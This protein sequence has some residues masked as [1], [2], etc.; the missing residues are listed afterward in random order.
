MWAIFNQ[1]GV[2]ALAPECPTPVLAPIVMGS[3]LPIEVAHE[4]TDISRA[5]NPEQQVRVIRGEA[6]VQH[7]D[8]ETAHS[9]P[10]SAPVLDADCV[11]AEKEAA[12][13]AAMG[14]MIG[15]VPAKEFVRFSASGSLLV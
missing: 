12:G 10:Q 13:V 4:N 8:L 3:K 7:E 5:P 1:S 6:I 2:V 14:Q 11:E 15:C 9:L